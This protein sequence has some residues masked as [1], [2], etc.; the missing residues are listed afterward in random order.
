MGG[1]ARRMEARPRARRA[2]ADDGADGCVDVGTD[3]QRG[4]LENAAARA[5]LVRRGAG[6]RQRAAAAR[7]VPISD[8]ILLE[9]RRANLPDEVS[10]N[11]GR[12]RSPHR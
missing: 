8:G 11:I 9:G 3:D 10:S 1:L 6:A 7:G 4:R 12:A 5:A 2:S